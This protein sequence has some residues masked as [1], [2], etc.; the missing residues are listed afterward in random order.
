MRGPDSRWELRR[1]V[2]TAEIGA[3]GRAATTTDS[4]VGVGAEI[5]RATGG[6]AW[7]ENAQQ[8]IRVSRG[9]SQ[10]TSSAGCAGW[11]PAMASLP[12]ASAA[13]IGQ[14]GMAEHTAT[15]IP[16]IASTK[17]AAIGIT[18]LVYARL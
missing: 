10:E 13:V 11:Q 6:A 12:A 5:S 4:G 7:V 16:E 1:V 15:G 17:R 3:V 18:L 14:P 2:A 9:V 8:E